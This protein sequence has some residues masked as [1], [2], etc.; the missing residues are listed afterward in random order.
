ML[1][2]LRDQ[3]TASTYIFGAVCT[4]QGKGAPLVL[5]TCNSK[6]MNLHLAEIAEMVAPGAVRLGGTY[7]QDWSFPPTSP[8]PLP[9]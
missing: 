5:P 9:P 4:K 7:R 6:A 1:N 2:R 8:S 3:C